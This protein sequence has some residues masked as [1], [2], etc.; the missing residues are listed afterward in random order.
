MIKKAF[1][2]G[3]ALALLS[4]FTV[5]VDCYSDMQG[6]RIIF[7]NL[8]ITTSERFFYVQNSYPLYQMIDDNP[9]TTW[10]FIT[11][12]HDEVRNKPIQLEIQ[13]HDDT[14]IK[15]IRMING[16][17][18]S[19]DLYTKNNRITEVVIAD[20]RNNR[21]EY[22]LEQT[23]S[24]QDITLPEP[25]GYIKLT[26][27]KIVRGSRYDDTCISEIVLLDAS[28]EDVLAGKEYFVFS[29]GGEYPRYI[30]FDRELRRIYAPDSDGIVGAGFSPRGD[31]VYFIN[32]EI[33]GMGFDVFDLKTRL[34][35]NYLEGYVLNL[36]WITDT[37]VKVRYYDFGDNELEKVIDVSP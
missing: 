36:E 1:L 16:Y 9:E 3:A 34:V 26:A 13:F 21:Y 23:L 33:D 8:T 4:L 7:P 37:R 30:L 6:P 10:V 35:R 32:S 31:M 15:T 29:S 20:D 24:F 28:G 27:K 22:D 12:A 14:Y 18:K 17:S 11:D 5:V 19:E 2:F 25:S